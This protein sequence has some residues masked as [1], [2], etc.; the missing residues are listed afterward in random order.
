MDQLIE[1]TERPQND[2]IY[3][4][5]G[6][7]Q[8]ADAGSMSSGLPEY[9]VDLTGA[10]KI[11]EIKP[12]PF[13][14]FHLP[15][16]HYYLRPEIKFK[17]GFT[18]GFQDQENTFYYAECGGKGLVI[19]L[20]DEPHLYAPRYA[21]AFF[22]VCKELGIRRGVAV[23][24]VYG[25]LPYD[26]DRHVSCSYSL[27]SMKEELDK[28]AVR[29]SNYEG[30]ATIG[31]YFVE[32]AGRLDREFMVMNALVPSY[33]FDDGSREML[34][35]PSMD[36]KEEEEGPIYQEPQGIRI[37]N[38][39]KAW[40]DVMIRLNHMFGLQLNLDELSAHSDELTEA[41]A[42]KLD[43]LN[44]S[45]PELDIPRYLE[46]VASDFEEMSFMPLDKMWE[47]ELGDLFNDL[48]LDP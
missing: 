32:R 46:N 19:F 28:Y 38:D 18:E 10:K 8:W 21:N 37:E 6:W 42:T 23:G 15:A 24:G 26:K 41:I 48:D 33:E 43:E 13:Y 16:T 17:D 9:L 29:F 1:L 5:A 20:G 3:L 25:R 34:F 39:Y 31:S 40:Y 7:R 14:M 36:V 12:D 35:P 45:V 44:R 47:E 30:G 4:I 2:E 11:G 22:E 27:K